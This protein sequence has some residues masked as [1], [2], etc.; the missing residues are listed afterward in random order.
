MSKWRGLFSWEDPLLSEDL[1]RVH[2][3]DV[4]G[5]A[6]FRITV[7]QQGAG[8]LNQIIPATCFGDLD[9]DG[10]WTAPA[11]A[12]FPLNGSIDIEEESIIG[13]QLGAQW[14][15][16]EDLCWNAEVTFTADAWGLGVSGLWRVN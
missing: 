10:T 5:D 11:L 7:Q 8:R 6:L 12:N 9:I 15:M 14:N 3:L 13:G 16:S 4:D 1:V 2:L